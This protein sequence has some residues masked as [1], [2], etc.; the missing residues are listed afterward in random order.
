MFFLENFPP[1]I[2]YAPS[3]IIATFGGLVQFNITAKDNDTITFEVI[4]K[5]AGAMV[6]T[7]QDVMNFAWNVSS[8]EKASNFAVDFF[9]ILDFCY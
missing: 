1:E 4:N 7:S 2:V 8:T 9:N 5:P 3:V 6:R